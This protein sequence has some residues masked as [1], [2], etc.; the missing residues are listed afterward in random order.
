MFKLRKTW[1]PFF[2]NLCL[3][4]LDARTHDI[5]PAWPITARVPDPPPFSQDNSNLNQDQSQSMTDHLRQQ[6]DSDSTVFRTRTVNQPPISVAPPKL[7]ELT[8]RAELYHMI[9]LDRME[10]IRHETAHVLDLGV[11]GEQQSKIR[12]TLEKKKKNKKRRPSTRLRRRANALLQA[13]MNQNDDEDSSDGEDN[14]DENQNE[15]KDIDGVDDDDGP[16]V[17]K[18]ST[19]LAEGFRI[20][21]P[22][23][24]QVR[25]TENLFGSTD[26]DYRENE[27]LTSAQTKT[28]TSLDADKIFEINSKCLSLAEQ[29][30]KSNELSSDEYHA[31]LKLLQNILQS[32]VKRLT[33]Q[34]N[35]SPTL[36]NNPTPQQQTNPLPFQQQLL[37]FAQQHAPQT[38]TLAPAPTFPMSTFGIDASR[39]VLQILATVGAPLS[40]IS[41]Y[42][43]FPFLPPVPPAPAPPPPL[44]SSISNDRHSPPPLIKRLH[45]ENHLDEENKRPRYDPVTGRETKIRNYE[46]ENIAPVP[47]LLEANI[48][49]L[50]K[51]KNSLTQ[52]FI[53]ISLS[54]RYIGIVQQLYI[55]K[56][57]CTVCGLRFTARQKQAYAVHLDWHFIENKQEK[58]LNT[59]KSNTLSQRTQNWFP[60]V[61]EWAIYEENLEEQVR[62]RKLMTN[63][64]RPVEKENHLVIEGENTVSTNGIISCPATGNDDVKYRSISFLSVFFIE[65]LLALFCLS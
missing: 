21:P 37:Q 20:K 46:E 36:I 64:V 25:S 52:N 31:T 50:K 26:K 8:S 57:Q 18:Q 35:N 12:K 53:R 22:A 24:F 30:Y 14:S 11:D 63:E 9:P 1:T 33:V 61:Q 19:A 56:D 44:F 5:D 15:E 4:N 55:G 59:N 10:R 43:F 42:N 27:N 32:E 45:D 16:F 7:S 3:Y 49:M 2:T 23:N 47:S 6:N 62:L 58:E 40:Y 29:K 39:H 48:N 34:Q 60:S 41:H 13:T 28:T 17:I 38:T 51:Y 54:R 65:F